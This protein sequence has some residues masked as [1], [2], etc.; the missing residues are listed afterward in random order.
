[1]KDFKFLCPLIIGT[2]PLSASKK[3]SRGKF[4]FAGQLQNEARSPGLVKMTF[5]LVDVGYRNVSCKI[6]F[7]CT[8]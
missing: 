2:S 3:Y 1:M 6:N 5:G 4:F 8:L 7:L